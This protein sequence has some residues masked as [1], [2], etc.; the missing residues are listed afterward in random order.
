MRTLTIKNNFSVLRNVTLS[1]LSVVIFS[2]D[3]LLDVDA[4]GTISGDVL[5]SEAIIQQS[6]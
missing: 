4:E 2:C 6:L 5:T 3:S 1:L